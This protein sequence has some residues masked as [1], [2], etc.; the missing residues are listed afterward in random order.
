MPPAFVIEINPTQRPYIDTY[1][2]YIAS[3]LISQY[4]L[5]LL[6]NDSHT[7][8]EF[9]AAMQGMMNSCQLLINQ[10]SN[11]SPVENK[12]FFEYFPNI[13]ESTD[14][15]EKLTVALNH[16]YKVMKLT[17]DSLSSGK[18]LS[19]GIDLNVAQNL[20]KNIDVNDDASIRK[21][22]YEARAMIFTYDF[23]NNQI[24]T[25]PVYQ[26]GYAYFSQKK[27]KA[28]KVSKDDL[29]TALKD[30]LNRLD[31]YFKETQKP[32][33]QILSD[34]KKLR[35][36]CDPLFATHVTSSILAMQNN[37]ASKSSMDYD[38]ILHQIL[39]IH[40][41]IPK[42]ASD[43]KNLEPSLDTCC[44][45]MWQM[46]Q[47]QKMITNES[48]SKDSESINL[49]DV[50]CTPE[51]RALLKEAEAA[52]NQLDTTT[53]KSDVL[54]R[55]YNSYLN[56]NENYSAKTKSF[57]FIFPD[58]G[59]DYSKLALTRQIFNNSLL[60]TRSAQAGT[61]FGLLGGTLVV[62]KAMSKALKR[63]PA[64]SLILSLGPYIGIKECEGDKKIEQSIEKT[65]LIEII[66]DWINSN[67][68]KIE[69]A[70]NQLKQIFNE[71]SGSIKTESNLQTL[72]DT[73]DF[74]QKNKDVT[75]I[76]KD[77][78]DLAKKLIQYNQC[79]NDKN[80]TTREELSLTA[81][82][83]ALADKCKEDGCYLYHTWKHLGMDAVADVDEYLDQCSK[84]QKKLIQD[85][86]SARE[87]V[88]V[89]QIE[90]NLRAQLLKYQRDNTRTESNQEQS[91]TN[92]RLQQI[93]QQ[94]TDNIE[95][96]RRSQQKQN[97]R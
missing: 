81:D 24:E 62:M 92:T 37:I 58:N 19:L 85:L 28:L 93:S 68:D 83:K 45:R 89:A 61:E 60:P 84:D 75:G 11:N 21:A 52:L 31:K 34:Y 67:Q 33:D 15:K 73:I 76:T 49:S 87:S 43:I 74:A 9:E 95:Q 77:A 48:K 29:D 82:E 12:I 32:D 72:I 20:Q 94:H 22:I 3:D 10:P 71:T 59:N 97:E 44:N 86:I 79:P 66:T 50:F 16:L 88:I 8:E 90:L 47:Y 36:K 69:N 51:Q 57:E 30:Y 46:K 14:T 1:I 64:T 6:Q 23:L 70:T 91:Q 80:K 63:Y 96:Q 65:P 5:S 17:D 56:A 54:L 27:E 4:S 39:D 42:N 40:N 26:N 25:S 7:K 18:Q 41:R 53:K 2:K 13:P 35:E 78:L 38:S 55:A